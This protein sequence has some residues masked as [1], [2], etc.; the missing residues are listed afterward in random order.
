MTA[1]FWTVYTRMDA[2]PGPSRDSEPETSAAQEPQLGRGMIDKQVQSIPNGAIAVNAALFDPDAS[3]MAKASG[4]GTRW[5]ETQYWAAQGAVETRAGGRGGVAFVETPLGPCV[6]RHYHRGGLAALV[7]LDRYLWNGAARTR[8]FREFDLLMRMSEAGLPVP[9]PIAARYVRDGVGYRADLL[10]RRLCPVHTLAEKQAAG[11][12]DR[13]LAE[14]VGRTLARFHRFG[15][16]HAD[17]NAHNVLVA[18][19]GDT[20]SDQVWLIDFDRGRLR[21]PAL[22]WQQGN[23]TRLR[24]SFVKLGAGGDLEDF[25]SRFWHPLLAA[26]HAAFGAGAINPPDNGAER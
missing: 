24:R 3:A 16:W 8:S 1:L 15:V 21:K 12:L 19:V 11:S 25:D 6:L 10:V 14:R 23:F 26:Y 5:F 20:R 9:E 18:D 4:V 2:H 7:S 17:L 13:S 22:A